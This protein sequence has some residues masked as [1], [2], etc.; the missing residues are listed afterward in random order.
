MRFASGASCGS[1][2]ALPLRLQRRPSAATAFA[3]CSFGRPDTPR[4]AT[5]SAAAAAADG[6]GASGGYDSDGA[7]SSSGDPPPTLLERG[8]Q[9]PALLVERYSAVQDPPRH[10]LT[11]S[12]ALTNFVGSA[13]LAYECGY[14]QAAL[15]NS[16]AAFLVRQMGDEGEAF[17]DSQCWRFISLVGGQG[18]GVR[19]RG[20][21]WCGAGRCLGTHVACSL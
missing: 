16:S 11:Y 15:S 4:R 17:E 14:D 7:S 10:G 6:R 18:R 2:L 9:L 5:S 12:D 13:C 21:V 1:P 8:A 3:C 20:W 19:V